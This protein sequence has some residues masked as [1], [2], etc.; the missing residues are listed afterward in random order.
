VLDVRAATYDDLPDIVALTTAHRVRLAEWAPLWWRKSATA[1]DDH[2]GWLASLIESP[3][4]TFRVV[5][6]DGVILGCAVSVPQPAQ[7][8]IDDVALIGDGLWPTAGVRLLQGVTERPALT[9]VPSGHGARIEGS[10]AAGLHRVSSYWIGKPRTGSPIGH[11]LGD[12]G[13]P[14]PPPHTFGGGLDPGA[15]GAL[16]FQ[17]G[18]GLV[19]GSPSVNAP[20]V[21]DPGGTVCVIDRIVGPDRPHLLD[22]ALALASQRG[23]VLVNVI[24]AEQDGELC[25]LASDRGLKRTVEV[26]A[27]P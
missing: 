27:W 16:C 26:F 2:P 24:I 3:R 23:D 22:G 13:V 4:F 14:A 1:D 12:R 11:P 7:W 17:D 10:L 18:D 15:D 9:C 19:V 8:F 25:R 21:Y 20:P 6:Q 5:H